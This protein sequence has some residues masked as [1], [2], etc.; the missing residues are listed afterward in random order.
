MINETSFYYHYFNHLVDIKP[1]KRK[2]PLFDID[3]WRKGNKTNG[4]KY[5][6]G[7]E[8]IGKFY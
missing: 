6:I 4:I 8:I 2:T 7:C 1:E 5:F 3:M